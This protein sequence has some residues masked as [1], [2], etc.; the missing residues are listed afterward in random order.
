MIKDD[1]VTALVWLLLLPILAVMFVL[2][3]F[4]K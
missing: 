2:W 1:L 3:M 4:R